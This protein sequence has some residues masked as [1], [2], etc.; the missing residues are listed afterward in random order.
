MCLFHSHTS[1][2][3][4]S[5]VSLSAATNTPLLVNIDCWFLYSLLQERI[6]AVTGTEGVHP[7]QVASLL[8]DLGMYKDTFVCKIRFM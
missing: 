4:Q 3:H 6:L 7:V 2:Q 8:K 5:Q 1:L